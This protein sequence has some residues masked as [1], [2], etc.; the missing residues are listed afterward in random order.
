MIR[1]S[2]WMIVAAALVGLPELFAFEAA[3]G[4][5]VDHIVLYQA[6]PVLQMR[7]SSAE[8]LAAYIK[9]LNEACAAV[10]TPLHRPE[11]LDIVVMVRP[12]K[13][14][15]VWLISSRRQAGDAELETLRSKLEGVPPVEVAV[16]PVAFAISAKIAGGDSKHPPAGPDSRPPIPKEWQDAAK[17]NA[18]MI[19]ISDDY[20]NLVWP[21]TASPA[22]P[23]GFVV[24]VLEPTGGKILRP[25]DWFYSEGHRDFT[26]MWTISR[27]DASNARPY[28]TG[29][30]I[31]AYIGIKE[32]AGVSAKDFI[33]DFA[34]QTKTNAEKVL[35]SCAES[36]QGLF[37]RICIETEEGPYHI[38]YSL[39]WGNDNL[40]IAVISI[41]GTTKELW[42]TYAR[43][44]ERMSAFELIDMKRSEN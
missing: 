18:P 41:S 14:S 15:R 24:Q 19:P 5:E 10:F 26:Y 17:G 38:M 12:G 42:A 28:V 32:K 31:Q 9:R 44:F 8:E 40:D 25:K 3:K 30:R 20:L 43:T 29:V 7:L 36:D 39:F 1:K 22:A 37:S 27:E 4:Y 6:D 33:L 16:G 21:D 13:R 23:D 2:L 34:G 35:S 11:T